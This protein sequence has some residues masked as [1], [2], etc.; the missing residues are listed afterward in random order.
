MNASHYAEIAPRK[1]KYLTRLSKIPQIPEAERERL[2]EVEKKFVFRVTDYYLEL[3]DW[4]DPD[5][6]IKQLIIPRAEELNAWGSLDAS[7]EA[8]VTVA[9][10]VQ[11]KYAD[12]CLL[13]CNEVCGAYCRYCFRKRLFMNDNDEVSLDVSE[14]LA[15]ISEHPE[16]SNVLLTGGDPLLMAPKKL[17]AIIEQLREIPHVKIIRLGS[18][19]PAFNPYVI[20]DKP[21]LVEGLARLS[22]SDAR[23]HLMAHFDH[24][25]ELT[26]AARE[27]MNRLIRAGVICVNQCPMIKG[28][29]DDADTLAELY[30]ELS[31]M[32]VTPYYI[33][34]G[35]PTEGNEAYEVPI[36]RGFELFSKARTRVS[37]LA[38]RARMCM[39]HET[40]KVEILA[41]D[42]DHIYTRYHRALNPEDAARFMIFRRDDKAYWLDQL[43][44]VGAG[45]LG[46]AEVA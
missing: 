33:F 12:T 28:V 21:E 25:R 22:R 11:H 23:I 4:N 42:D 37:G 32:G 29:N 41:V 40:G 16:I 35:R 43:V 8:Q 9:K 2:A 24:P 7:N 31:F 6:P 26:P 36:V 18:K 19:M 20:L 39:S 46:E 15:Y 10:G 3:I 44:P 38:A 45:V 5:D 27:A 1:V 13:L 34:Q 14:G 30:R 17:L